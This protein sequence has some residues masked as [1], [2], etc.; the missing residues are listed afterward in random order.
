MNVKIGDIYYDRKSNDLFE[1]RGIGKFSYRISEGCTYYGDTKTGRLEWIG[2]LSIS[3]LR[4]YCEPAYLYSDFLTRDNIGVRVMNKEEKE[5]IE[6]KTCHS[7]KVGEIFYDENANKLFELLEIRV[8]EVVTSVKCDYYEHAKQHCSIRSYMSIDYFNHY[9]VRAYSG[10]SFLID[11]GCGNIR[12]P[13]QSIK[14][15]VRRARIEP[16]VSTL[17]EKPKKYS[18]L[19]T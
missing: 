13:Y 4:N 8:G 11:D 1:I 16:T 14:T 5:S 15:S 3:Y 17:P 19:L 7:A 10:S 9:C 2:E 12:V 6:F 18:S